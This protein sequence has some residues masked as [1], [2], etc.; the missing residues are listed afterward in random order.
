LILDPLLRTFCGVCICSLLSACVTSGIGGA[1]SPVAAN[2][3]TVSAPSQLI[4][5]L[6]GGLVARAQGDRLSRADRQ[7]ALQNEYRALEYTAPGE[8]V[9]WQG[10]SINGRIVPSQP[11]RVGS[12][13]C[14]QYEHTIIDRSAESVVRGTACRGEDGSW[15]LL[16]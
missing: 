16:S 1:P 14:R 7:L 5:A 15:T 13:D 6:N 2:P 11:Y 9:L 4:S 3:T 8:A 12:Q 10:N